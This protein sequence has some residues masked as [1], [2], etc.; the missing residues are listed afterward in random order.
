MQRLNF[1]ADEK[2]RKAASI[3]REFLL[4]EGLLSPGDKPG[5]EPTGTI[6]VGSKPF[7]EQEILAEMMATL[8]EAKMPLRVRRVLNLGGTKLCFDSLR[9]GDLD[10]YAEYT[11][12]GLVSI[13][14]RPVVSDPE[15]SYRVVKEA[16]EN[17]F[18][19]VWLQP[20]GFNNTYT[21]TMRRSQAERLG[22]STI[23][24]LARYLNGAPPQIA[25]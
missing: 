4:S 21:L 3:A 18:G 23:S 20:F 11:G 17:D 10:L 2:G 8:V 7:T 5:E 15:E 1:A 22:L 9:S 12:T 6:T 13:L 24:D 16:F 25:R 14:G 19:L